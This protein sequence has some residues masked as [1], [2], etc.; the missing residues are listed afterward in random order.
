MKTRWF[1]IV[2]FLSMVVSCS[3]IRKEVRALYAWD[4]GWL[5]YTDYGKAVLEFER[6]I[7]NSRMKGGERK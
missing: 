1:I 5:G 7:D 4:E 6:L 2:V 3:F